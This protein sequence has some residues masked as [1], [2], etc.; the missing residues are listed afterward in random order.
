MRLLAVSIVGYLLGSFPTSDV[1]ARVVARQNGGKHVDLRTSGTQNPGALNAA[2]VLGARW[3]LVVLAGDVAKGVLASLAG[4]RVAGA[5]GAYA[6]GTTAVIG[7]CAPPWN[8]FRGGKGVATSA[9]TSLALFPVYA[10]ADVGLAAAV[11]ALSRG[12]AEWA[13]L[14]ASGV[15]IAAATYWWAGKKGNAWG[16]K[17]TIGLPIYAAIT[18][19]VI[20]YRFLQSSEPRVDVSRPLEDINEKP[21]D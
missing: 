8:G 13:T 5:N 6:A 2:K 17:A 15:F 20:A 10:P 12:R 7:H 21:A 11:L 19:A 9:G 14:S 3:G 16:P 18:S 1:V 4:R